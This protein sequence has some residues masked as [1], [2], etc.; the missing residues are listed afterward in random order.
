MIRQQA[1]SVDEKSI[2]GGQQI[3]TNKRLLFR[4]LSARAATRL[5]GDVIDFLPDDPGVLG[6]WCPRR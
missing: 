3:L 4:P 6:K 1:A 2:W 5:I